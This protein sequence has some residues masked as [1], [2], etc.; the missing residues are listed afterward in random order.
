MIAAHNSPTSI[1]GILCQAGERLLLK[2]TKRLCPTWLK[3]YHFFMCPQAVFTGL[4]KQKECWAPRTW[5]GIILLFYWLFFLTESLQLQFSLCGCYLFFQYCGWVFFPFLIG[6]SFV[7]PEFHCQYSISLLP[8]KTQNIMLPVTDFAT[9]LGVTRAGR[10]L[11]LGHC[12]EQKLRNV[13]SS[14]LAIAL[15]PLLF[16]LSIH[17]WKAQKKNF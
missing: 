11:L 12:W 13:E 4:K 15:K 5:W 1:L 17:A 9:C 3:A 16:P 6:F 10:G 2:A 7:S 8:S 14:T